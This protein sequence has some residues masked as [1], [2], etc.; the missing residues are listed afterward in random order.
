MSGLRKFQDNEAWRQKLRAYLLNDCQP[1]K[2]AK[3][4]ESKEMRYSLNIDEDI[5]NRAKKV[6]PPAAT[7]QTTININED[8]IYEGAMGQFT[9]RDDSFDAFERMCDKTGSDP[10]STLFQYL[11]SEDKSQVVAMAKDRSV[12]RNLNADDQK[13]IDA[14]RRMLEAVGTEDLLDN[15][16]PVKGVECTQIEDVE[17]PSRFWD[18][19]NTLA[20]LDE[21]SMEPKPKVSP[22][23]MVGLM[24]PSTI[25]EDNELDSD[26]SSQVSFQSARTLKTNASSCY[27]TATDNSLSGTLLSVDDLF[28]AAIAKAKPPGMSKGEE[29]ELLSDLHGSLKE[30]TSA[31]KGHNEPVEEEQE[32][33]YAENTIIELSSSDNE[34]VQLI[35]ELKQENISRLDDKSVTE[36][37]TL[38]VTPE[39]DVLTVE[40]EPEDKEND[41]NRSMHFNDTME[42]MQYMMQKGM[43]YMTGA[44]APATAPSLAAA[45]P[46]TPVLAKSD[47]FVMSPKPIRKTPK[48]E[49]LE[50]SLPLR[51]S[52]KPQT[53]RSSPC[54]AKQP[55]KHDLNMEWTR[56]KFFGASS[57]IPQRR[58]QQIKQPAYANIV[59]PIRTYT[60]KSGTAPLMALFRQTSADVFSTLAITELEQESRL[61]QP[62]PNFGKGAGSA[63]IS[64]CLLEGIDSTAQLLP[65]KAYISSEIKHVVDERT[66][67]PMPSVPRIQKY[68]NSAVEPTVLRHD[69]KMK[70]P[71]DAPPKTSTSSHIPRRANH[72]LA[73]LSLASGDVSLYTI[74]DAQK[75]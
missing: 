61:C 62:K 22:V 46:K 72:S 65:K 66:P 25:I 1:K 42:E 54:K 28:Y 32:S 64:G 35:P 39:A 27:E 12:S 30:L 36:K 8:T 4:E 31:S 23:K 71:S 33:E 2:P 37:Q 17:A 6:G 60:Q 56:K 49:F 11:H 50:P 14:L 53:L 48:S 20:G 70:M 51:P 13:E 67:L 68:L 18:N 41:E 47:T 40:D 19:D 44:A 3:M 5:R 69:G 58:Q 15:E 10:D 55:L 24:R 74:R 7:S 57:G 45:K 38:D 43:E 9:D 16:S 26:I 34:D 73:D 63:E 75:F 29:K 21:S 59:S 52:N